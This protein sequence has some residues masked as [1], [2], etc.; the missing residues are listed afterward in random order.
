MYRQEFFGMRIDSAER[1]IITAI[2][3]HMERSESDAIRRV[4]REKAAE[5]GLI[6]AQKSSTPQPEKLTGAAQLLN[7]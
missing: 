2:A 6:K 5:L 7:C 4:I 1:Q 3:E